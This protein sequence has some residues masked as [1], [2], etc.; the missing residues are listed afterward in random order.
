MFHKNWR[1]DIKVLSEIGDS[2]CLFC[3]SIYF[4]GLCTI[5]PSL[6]TQ[7][8]I[9]LLIPNWSMCSVHERA[10]R[11][12]VLYIVS[13]KIHSL[14]SPVLYPRIILHIILYTFY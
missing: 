14:F 7:M 11:R 12:I 13:Y 3:R 6:S 5:V 4:F 10:H 2:S 9:D 8:V 1:E